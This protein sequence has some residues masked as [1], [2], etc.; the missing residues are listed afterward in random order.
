MPIFHFNIERKII[1]V[2]KKANIFE[3][4]VPCRVC[5][6]GITKD[7]KK[8]IGNNH[9]LNL[10]NTVNGSLHAFLVKEMKEEN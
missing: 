7:Y 5:V 8:L 3:H 1:Q 9:V 4:P 2:E 6:E 10:D